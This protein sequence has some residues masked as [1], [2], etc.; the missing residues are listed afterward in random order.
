MVADAN[1]E[2][3]DKTLWRHLLQIVCQDA[4][5]GQPGGDHLIYLDLN[6][7]LHYNLYTFYID[8]T[9]SETYGCSICKILII[10]AKPAWL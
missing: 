9:A 4:D 8:L 2:R 6:L 5:H 10:L 7:C 3:A 1:N